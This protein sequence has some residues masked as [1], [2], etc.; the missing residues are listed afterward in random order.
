MK[1]E[2]FVTKAQA[3]G[4]SDIHLV[5][6]MVPCCRVDGVIREMGGEPLTAEQCVSLAKELTGSEIRQAEAVGEMDLSL[7]I[8]GSRCRVNLFRQQASWSAAIRLLKDHIPSLPELGLPKAAEEFPEYDQG[9]VLVAGGSGSGKST[10]LAAML[11]Q[12]N[13]T[14]RKHILTVEN[15]IEY[16]YAPD[17]C[18]INQ[19]EIGRDTGS[20][21][22]GI[23]AAL[24]EDSDVILVGELRDP[25]TIEMAITAAEMGH[26]VLGAVHTGSAADT[27]A[28]ITGVF[29]EERQRQIRLRLSMTLKAVLSQRLLPKAG[30]GRVPA[31]EIMKTNR[32]IQEL[33]REGRTSQLI[34]AV[35]AAGGAD[36]ILMEQSL[37]SLYEAGTISR[38]TC[39]SA[40]RARAQR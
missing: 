23:R 14:Q 16:I 29:P 2:T 6:G 11:G 7:T 26:L 19:R 18:I 17:K 24:R 3:D 22:I 4:A 30:G 9:L 20:F 38:E 27:I 13:H 12:I 15:P 40:L 39:E 5:Q 1:I 21:A 37:Q 32:A 33:I 34:A 35:Q 31:C 25:E 8:A 28:H 10:T 36:G